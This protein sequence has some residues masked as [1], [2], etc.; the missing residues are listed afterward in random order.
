MSL[1]IP[2]LLGS[3][4]V[5]SL[6]PCAYAFAA[7][8]E[9]RLLISSVTKGSFII[10]SIIEFL[11]YIYYLHARKRLQ[12]TN[13][14]HKP[15]NQMERARLFWNCVQTIDDVATWSEGWFYQKKD[16]THPDFKDIQREN[17]ALW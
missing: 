12:Q 13:K 14:P 3:A 6:V 10:W 7:I 11:F 2:N 16:H 1:P 9:T 17:L 8:K 15:L 4:I 5:V